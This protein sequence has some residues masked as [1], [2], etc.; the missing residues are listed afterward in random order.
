M[1]TSDGVSKRRRDPTSSVPTRSVLDQPCPLRYIRSLH[2]PTRRGSSEAYMAEGLNAVLALPGGLALADGESDAVH[3]V[4]TSNAPQRVLDGFQA[5]CCLA[6]DDSSDTLF[7][8]DWHGVHALRLSDGDRLASCDRGVDGKRLEPHDLCYHDGKLYAAAGEDGVVVLNASTMRPLMDIGAS[9]G[10]PIGSA[11][12]I[13][14]WSVAAAGDAVY[15]ADSEMDRVQVFGF[16]GEFRGTLNAELREVST[17]RVADGTVYVSDHM[18][19][20]SYPHSEAC[21]GEVAGQRLAQLDM[22]PHLHVTDGERHPG[23][24][25]LWVE[26]ASAWMVSVDTIHELCVDP[27]A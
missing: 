17:V 19:L 20:Q 27:N 2:D 7:V 21:G 8:G 16:G 18:R 15:V 12:L 22:R 3:L 5:P 24:H 4:S 23:V 9:L 14:A 11:E 6:Y 13:C 10:S 25:G 26:G 1:D